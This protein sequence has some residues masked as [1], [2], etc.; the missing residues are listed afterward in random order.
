MGEE[1]LVVVGLGVVSGPAPSW[2]SKRYS[3]G[4]MCRGIASGRRRGDGRCTDEL[5]GEQGNTL[6]FHACYVN[7]VKN[8]IFFL[9]GSRKFHHSLVFP[10]ISGG[11]PLHIVMAR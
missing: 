4:G 1:V 3:I 9:C 5:L 11:T 2:S 8:A 10:H 6:E 7:S